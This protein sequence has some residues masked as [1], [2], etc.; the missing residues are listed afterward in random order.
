MLAR[1]YLRHFDIKHTFGFCKNTLGWTTPRL[2]SPEQTDRR[3]WLIAT[4]HTQLRLAPTLVADQ[5]L[6]WQKPTKAG[7][8]TPS[9]TR[10]GFRRLTAT[11]GTPT[12]PPKSSKAGPSR[13]KRTRK[14]PR[15]RHPGIHKTA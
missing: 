1:A 7:K 4:A 13:P 6:P 3:T 10:R 14:G 5:Q 12:N 11:L 15:T 9:R 2:C 8:L